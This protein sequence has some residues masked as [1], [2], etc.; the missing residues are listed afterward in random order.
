M[1][2]PQERSTYC[3][4]P[5]ELQGI[6]TVCAQ[7]TIGAAVFPAHQHARVVSYCQADRGRGLVRIGLLRSTKA[8]PPTTRTREAN[9]EPIRVRVCVLR[10]RKRRGLFFSLAIASAKDR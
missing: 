4:P 9:V 2:F 1:A 8:V 3:P 5:P 10:K 7:A 6:D